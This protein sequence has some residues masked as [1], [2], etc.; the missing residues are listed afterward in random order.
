[1]EVSRNGKIERWFGRP[2]AGPPTPRLSPLTAFLLLAAA[3]TILIVIV[4]LN[5]R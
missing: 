2:D 3:T 5:A 4:L 1:M